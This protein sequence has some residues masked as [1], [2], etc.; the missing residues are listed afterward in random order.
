MLNFLYCKILRN[1]YISLIGHYI[2][3][4][5]VNSNVVIAKAGAHRKIKHALQYRITIHCKAMNCESQV[6]TQLIS[7]LYRLILIASE[8]NSVLTFTFLGA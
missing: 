4:E 5:V 7:L 6:G 8:N 2:P 1:L 3:T